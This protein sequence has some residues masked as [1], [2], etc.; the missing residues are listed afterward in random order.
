MVGDVDPQ[1][2]GKKWEIENYWDRFSSR[3]DREDCVDREENE[4]ITVQTESI[5]RPTPETLGVCRKR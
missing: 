1:S 4:H 3:D 5:C 2:V